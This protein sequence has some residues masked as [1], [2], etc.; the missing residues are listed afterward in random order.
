VSFIPS[1]DS[2]LEFGSRLAVVQSLAVPESVNRI[3]T[4]Y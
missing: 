4:E 1:Q 3:L 2:K